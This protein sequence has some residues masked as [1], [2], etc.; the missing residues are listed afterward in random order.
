[1]QYGDTTEER[2]HLKQQRGIDILHDDTVDALIDLDGYAAQGA[3]LELLVGCSN[4]GIHIAASAGTPCWVLV[5][6]GLA[7]LWSGHLERDECPWYPHV[8]LLR[9]RAGVAID[10]RG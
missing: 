7:R 3:A 10:W 5:P 6:G 1:M 2:L 8:R 4:S 9:P